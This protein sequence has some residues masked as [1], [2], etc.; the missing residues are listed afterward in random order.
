[1]KEKKF[2]PIHYHEFSISCSRKK[3]FELLKIDHFNVH[4]DN[5]LTL[6]CTSKMRVHLASYLIPVQ[7]CKV[8]KNEKDTHTHNDDDS[9]TKLMP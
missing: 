4:S 9:G 2:D 8:I 1:M 7:I 6:S 5:V 3:M